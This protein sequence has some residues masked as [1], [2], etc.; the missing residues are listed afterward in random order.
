MPD[1]E[2]P[3][4]PELTPIQPAAP[5][6]AETPTLRE[7]AEECRTLRMLCIGTQVALII[8]TLALCPFL[9]LAT[10]MVKHETEEK[11]PVVQ[12]LVVNTQP[13][14]QEFIKALQVFAKTDPAF[15]PIL[16]RYLTPGAVPGMAPA[17]NA[18]PGKGK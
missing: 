18:P 15:Q 5:A 8:V 1:S 12:D 3:L 7:L 2:L 13:K 11:R 16:A 14:I 4:Q 6:S 9:M 17:T 10:R